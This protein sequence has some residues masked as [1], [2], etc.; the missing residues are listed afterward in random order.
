MRDLS[1]IM[2]HLKMRGE[3]MNLKE[4]NDT[5]IY[6]FRMLFSKVYCIKV[7]QNIQKRACKIILFKSI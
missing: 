3:E 5:K 6:H 2:A 4:E 7:L 1:E